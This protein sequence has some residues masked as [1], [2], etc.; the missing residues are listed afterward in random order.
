MYCLGLRVI[1][2]HL[3]DR[4]HLGPVRHLVVAYLLLSSMTPVYY[5]SSQPV[6]VRYLLVDIDV[7]RGGE[8]PVAY[9][10]WNVSTIHVS[11]INSAVIINGGD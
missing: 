9:L 5:S 8:S 1:A 7:F 11:Y 10:E 2:P 6:A 4:F 3:P